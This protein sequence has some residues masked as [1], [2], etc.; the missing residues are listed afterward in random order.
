MGPEDRVDT[1]LSCLLSHQARSCA[2]RES[3]TEQSRRERETEREV[4]KRVDVTLTWRQCQG[5]VDW[6]SLT[7]NQCSMR[8]GR[9]ACVWPVRD[10]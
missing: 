10:R 9:I 4:K 7:G 5:E 1:S 3:I 8:D 2:V 6:V